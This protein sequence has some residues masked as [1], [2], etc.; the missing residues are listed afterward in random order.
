[1]FSSVFFKCVF[2]DALQDLAQILPNDASHAL[3]VDDR[4]EVW[5]SAVRESQLLKV[6]SG[7]SVL[8]L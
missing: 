1:M 5:P 2:K 7:F 8:G 4:E 6:G 3:V